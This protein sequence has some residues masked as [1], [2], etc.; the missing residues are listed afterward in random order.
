MSPKRAT[1]AQRREKLILKAASQRISLAQDIT[2]LETPLTIAYRGFQLVRYV[3]QH[4][5]LM[6]GVTTAVSVIR[7][8]RV[9]RWLKTGFSALN[10]ARSVSDVF[11]RK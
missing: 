10:L 3:K 5:I 1:I 9:L 11:I 8:S 2:P 6:L 7:P 4:P